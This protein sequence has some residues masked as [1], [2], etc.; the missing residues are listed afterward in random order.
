VWNNTTSGQIEV[1]SLDGKPFR[2]L[3]THGAPPEYVGFDPATDE[4]RG[5]YTLRWDLTR[6]GKRIPWFWVVETD[7]PDAPVID[8]RIRHAST[9]S[10]RVPDR[11]WQPKDQ[12]IVVGVVPA[13][14]PFEISTGIECDAGTFPDPATA[15][16]TTASPHLQ[17]EL[18]E[19]QRDEQH[20]NYR[21][22]VTPAA[23]APPGLLYETIQVHAGGYVVPLRI[24]GRIAG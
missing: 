6:F 14:E 18:L 11:H 9:L 20:L 21:V 19:T 7:R 24:I 3:R 17:A 4:P 13:G 15:A 1:K 22:R 8:A 10:P 2:V 23:E 12:R 5:V 16:V